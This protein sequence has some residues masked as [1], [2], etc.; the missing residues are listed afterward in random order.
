LALDDY[1]WNVTSEPLLAIAS[2]VRVDLNRLSAVERQQ[3]RRLNCDLV[4]IIA[5]KVETQEDYRQACAEDIKLFQGDYFFH[6]VLLKKTKMPA[7]TAFHFEIVRLLCHHPIDVRQVS[8]LLMR[9]AGLT[10]RLLR[11][12]NS[13]IYAI[14]SE[15][16]SIESAIFILGDDTLRRVLSLAVLSELNADQ[17]PEIL[18]M[19][20]VRARFCELAAKLCSLDPPEQ[21]LLGMFSLAAAMLRIPIE[22]LTRS[23]PLR[24]KICDALEG[25]KN[26]ERRLLTWIESH[27]RGEWTTS[28]IAVQSIGLSRERLNLCYTDA[29]V[30]AQDAIPSVASA[31]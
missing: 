4:S 5:K 22:E 30:W 15:V 27:E 9:D 12:V 28:D 20:F 7:N 29:I 13:P 1:S 8:R 10:Y 31:G 11:L 6:P 24:N 25:T 3:L 19:A 16:R 2:Y 23:L 17:P 26:P 21:F 18:R 14:Q